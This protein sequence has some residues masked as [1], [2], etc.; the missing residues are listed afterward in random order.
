MALLDLQQSDR[1]NADS[2]CQKLRAEVQ[3]MIE[4]TD[5][6]VTIKIKE[7]NRIL[8]TRVTELDAKTD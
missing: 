2:L 3:Q 5:S 8:S 1:S 4:E 6:R 7:A